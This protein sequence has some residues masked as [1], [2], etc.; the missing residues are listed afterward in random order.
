M[1]NFLLDKNGLVVSLLN[2]GTSGSF[3]DANDSLPQIGIIDADTILFSSL[4]TSLLVTDSGS[5]SSVDGIQ[6][7]VFFFNEANPNQSGTLAQTLHLANGILTMYD[8]VRSLEHG[9]FLYPENITSSITTGSGNIAAG[10]YQYQ[11]VFSD[12]WISNY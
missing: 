4:F 10:Q 8:G 3:I 9:F 2:S 6:T 7:S 1:F 12:G 11:V 5:F